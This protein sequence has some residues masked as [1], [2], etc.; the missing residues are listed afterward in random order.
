MKLRSR[1]LALATVGLALAAPGCAQLQQ[2][3][4]QPREWGRCALL[5]AAVGAGVGTGIGFAI[6]NNVQGPNSPKSRVIT[7]T[8]IGTGAGAVLGL[9]TGHFICDPVSYTHLTLPTICSV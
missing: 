6:A 3:I 7:G 4:E 9:V 1:F 8:L 5:G 2:Q